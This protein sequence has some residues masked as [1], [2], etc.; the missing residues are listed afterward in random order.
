MFRP[1]QGQPTLHVT[2]PLS[3]VS[4][5][6]TVFLSACVISRLLPLSFKQPEEISKV[7]YVPSPNDGAKLFSLFGNLN[8]KTLSVAKTRFV[9]DGLINELSRSLQL[10]DG[11]L[12][13]EVLPELQ[14][15]RYFASGD[16]GDIFTTF[17]DVYQ[18]AGRPV[19][20]VTLDT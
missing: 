20:P 15:L 19:A 10:G 2:V 9:D 6:C 12:P 1:R 13:L 17:I 18:N 3:G 4:P 11:E 5:Y 8:A 16:T 14:E 7:K